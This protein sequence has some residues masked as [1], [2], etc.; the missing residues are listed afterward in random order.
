M[1]LLLF[2]AFLAFVV[3]CLVLKPCDAQ[4]VSL[5]GITICIHQIANAQC[6]VCICELHAAC[7][8][9]AASKQ[10]KCTMCS[11]Y[12]T[13]LQ[14]LQDARLLVTAGQCTCGH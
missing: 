12:A 7:A 8:S 9:E 1:P 14:R 6:S 11:L 4:T 10:C 3:I 5:A 13:A 2:I